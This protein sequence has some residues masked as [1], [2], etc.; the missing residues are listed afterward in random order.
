MLSKLHNILPH[1][2]LITQPSLHYSYRYTYHILYVTTTMRFHCMHACMHHNCTT[3]EFK[4]KTPST[5]SGTPISVK[6]KAESQKCLAL[7]TRNGRCTRTSVVHSLTERAWSTFIIIR[8]SEVTD[9]YS[10]QRMDTFAEPIVTLNFTE[11]S[12]IGVTTDMWWIHL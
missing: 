8:K 6:Q 4:R 2:I 11:V 12:S 9:R 3:W 5:L 1:W 7:K 10:C